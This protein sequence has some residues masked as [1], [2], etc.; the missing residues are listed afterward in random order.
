MLAQVNK[1][2]QFL[3][4]NQQIIVIN[5]YKGN[6][7]IVM[8]RREYESSTRKL[9]DD[10]NTYMETNRDP[11]SRIEKLT[12]DMITTWRLNNKIT[13]AQETELK[14]HNSISPAS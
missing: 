11:T 7:A 4:E 12:N 14:T 9:L 5:A 2:K 1:T 6:T 8:D 3:Y 13:D 10:N